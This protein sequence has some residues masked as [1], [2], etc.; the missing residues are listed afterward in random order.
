MQ[1]AFLRVLIGVGLPVRIAVIYRCATGGQL[2]RYAFFCAMVTYA[3]L[4][5]AALFVL[6]GAH[7]RSLWG[8]TRWLEGTLAAA[9]AIEAFWGVARHFRNIRGFGWVLIV[10]IIAVSAGA[11]EI[12]GIVRANWIGDMRTGLLVGQYVNVALSLT[13]IL[14]IAFFRQFQKT[15]VRPNAILH[16]RVLGII[17]GINAVGFFIAQ[18]SGGQQGFLSGAVLAASPT[19]TYLWWLTG[20]K[21]A[22]ESLPFPAPN[23]STEEYEASEAKHGRTL[24]DLKRAASEALKKLFRR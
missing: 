3:L 9:A 6:S 20:M 8:N 2:K 19:V 4:G 11:A 10:I 16:L 7:Y 12:V 18:I 15:P 23:M 22:G 14:S 21:P 17:Y 13:A 1:S 5:S 24:R